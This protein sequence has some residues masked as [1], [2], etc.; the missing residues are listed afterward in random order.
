MFHQRSA[1][2][3]ASIPQK[4]N[5]A[6]A[7]A[8]DTDQ[9]EGEEE[10]GDD[11]DDE[12]RYIVFFSSFAQRSLSII[13]VYGIHICLT[14]LSNHFTEIAPLSIII[15]FSHTAIQSC[16]RDRSRLR[17]RLFF[18]MAQRLSLVFR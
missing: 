16:H 3:E 4:A 1:N 9:S 11:G 2:H 13:T 15:C 7:E 17:M 5:V 12:V 14:Q 8:S 10:L 6:D 18:S